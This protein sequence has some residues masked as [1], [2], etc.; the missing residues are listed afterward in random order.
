MPEFLVNLSR[1]FARLVKD[2]YKAAKNFQEAPLQ[3]RPAFADGDST[4]V[5]GTENAREEHMR[6]KY[7]P[8][9]EESKKQQQ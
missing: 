6:E 2:N 3:G 5:S 7:K 8:L 4:A 9:A 1:S